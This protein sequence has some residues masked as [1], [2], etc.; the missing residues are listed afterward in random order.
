[1]LQDS[2]LRK[3]QSLTQSIP[4]LVTDDTAV[5]IVISLLNGGQKADCSPPYVTKQPLPKC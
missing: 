1:L 4:F 2:E 5:S 3:G